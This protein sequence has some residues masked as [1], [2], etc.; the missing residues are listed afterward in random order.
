[1]WRLPIHTNT[2]KKLDIVN[3]HLEEQ[4][5]KLE[6]IGLKIKKPFKYTDE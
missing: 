3:K 2:K 5:T 4:K 6:G 1:M